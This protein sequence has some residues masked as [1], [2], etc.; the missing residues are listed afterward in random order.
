MC[1]EI[2]K[3]I[4]IYLLISNASSSLLSRIRNRHEYIP[5]TDLEVIRN[6]DDKTYEDLMQEIPILRQ[7]F[8]DSRRDDWDA[9]PHTQADSVGARYLAAPTSASHDMTMSTATLPI[10]AEHSLSH[11]R[12]RPATQRTHWPRI[13]HRIRGRHSQEEEQQQLAEFELRAI[14]K[15]PH[16][17][18]CYWCGLN[19]TLLPNTTVCYEAFQSPKY[20]LHGISRFFRAHCHFND[21]RHSTQHR[22]NPLTPRS[23]ASSS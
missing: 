7:V 18:S 2:V 11:T 20:R 9:A 5:D 3:V 23:T 8:K 22:I 6:L 15:F 19:D 13:N 1:V 21:T 12:T 16:V 17:F 10:T 14:D 4:C